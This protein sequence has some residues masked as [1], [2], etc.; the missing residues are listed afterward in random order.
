MKFLPQI[1]LVLASVALF[2]CNVD[3]RKTMPGTFTDPSLEKCIMEPDHS[4]Y[5]CLPDQLP[6]GQKIALLIVIDPHGDGLTAMQKFKEALK[7]L[8]VV[9]AGSQKLRNN[10]SGFE[11][12]LENLKN[13]LLTKYPADPQQIIVAGFSGGAR[14]AYYYGMKHPVHGIIMFGA[15]PGQA[16]VLGQ[17]KKIYAVSGTRDFNFSEQYRPLFNDMQKRT[18]YVNDYFRGIHTWPPESYIRES[19]VFCLKEDSPPFKVSSQKYSK[20][21]LSEAESLEG[22]NDLFFAG[23]ALEKAWY[24]ATGNQQ[25]SLPGKIEAFKSNP[26]WTAYQNKF[27]ALLKSEEQKKSYYVQKLADPD[28][29]WWSNELSTLLK[30]IDLSSD[31]AETDYYYRLKGFLGIY[32]Y[33]QINGLLQNQPSSEI[34][35]RLLWIY[36]KVEPDSEDLKKFKEKI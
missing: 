6:S 2:S 36:E 33:S 30:Q 31:P 5:V 8:P 11:V 28:T 24:F 12:S 17:Q 9:I 27:E 4:Y 19:V 14:M 10:Y 21:F 26:Q 3:R 35:H 7:D 25:K 23:K 13:D 15:G 22:E 29:S 16:G 32:L 34:I 1:V 18:N 20:A